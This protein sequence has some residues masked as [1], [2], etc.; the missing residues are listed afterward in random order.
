MKHFY[1][2]VDRVDT[3]NCG[4]GTYVGQMLQCLKSEIELYVTI[5]VLDSSES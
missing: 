4:I 5:V 1:L 3:E 2:V